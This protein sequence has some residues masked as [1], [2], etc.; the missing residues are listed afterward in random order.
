MSM[1]EPL[2]WKYLEYYPDEDEENFDGVHYGGIKGIKSDA[3]DHV[4]EEYKAWLKQQENNR[5]TLIK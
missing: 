1:A 2:F 4:K 3:P 5:Q